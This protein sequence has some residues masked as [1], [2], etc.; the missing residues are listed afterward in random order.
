MNITSTEKKRRII[1]FGLL[2]TALAVVVVFAALVIFAPEKPS[3]SAKLVT[4]RPESVRGQAGGEGSEEYNQKLK[5]HDTR[6]ANEALK[7]GESF[8]P[9]P[10]GQRKPVVVKKEDTR[11]A[12][13][14][15]APVRTAPV[16]TQATDNTML[17]R[18]MD[19]L[20][21]LD[22][23]LSA[24]SAGEGKIVYLHEFSEENPTSVPAIATTEIAQAT[25]LTK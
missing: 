21:T 18:M 10:V 7:S 14:P 16:R 1:M 19:D 9:T 2:G 11:P 5:E 24:V 20:N 4:P 12:P 13:P 22:T 3:S 8:V 17:K 6:L 15:V 23:K 25:N